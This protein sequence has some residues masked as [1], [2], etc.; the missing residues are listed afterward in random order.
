MISNNLKLEIIDILEDM[1]S[2]KYWF[3]KHGICY[4]MPYPRSYSVGYVCQFFADWDEFSGDNK[5]PI[6]H[7]LEDCPAVS[8][9]CYTFKWLGKYGAARRRLVKHLIKCIKEDLND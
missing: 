1:L 7:P 3:A 6:M 5:Y 4:Y 9:R 8:Y 2:Y